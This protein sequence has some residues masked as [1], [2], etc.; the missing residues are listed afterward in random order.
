MIQLNYIPLKPDFFLDLCILL[1]SFILSPG[2]LRIT[3]WLPEV[4]LIPRFFVLSRE[5]RR[6]FV[7]SFLGF[8]I[9][10]WP[11]LSHKT[12][13]DSVTVGVGQAVRLS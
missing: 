13:P 7:D 9:A 6:H 10:Q 2:P 11:E 8:S 12:I 1:H 3:D 4:L 5:E